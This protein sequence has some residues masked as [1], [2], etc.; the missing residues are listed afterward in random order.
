M[1]SAY[2]LALER[3]E[4]DGIDR[5]RGDALSSETR[6]Q[7]AELRR[8]AEAR[9]AEIEILHHKALTA[10]KDPT[11]REKLEAE[12]RADRRVIE[13]RRERDLERLRRQA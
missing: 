1:K 3:M 6:E 7:I 4:Q 8:R 11:Q 9:L 12:Y 13:E 2:E 10:T 5:P